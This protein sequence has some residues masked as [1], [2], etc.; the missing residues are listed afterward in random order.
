MPH[1][2]E[3]LIK[4]GGIEA[5]LKNMGEDITELKNKV[6]IQNGRVGKM[7]SWKTGMYMAG[8]VVVFVIVGVAV[9]LWYFAG[10]VIAQGEK[11]ASVS[12]KVNI[13]QTK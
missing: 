6:G 13:I 3:I 8:S 5:T 9:M 4:L 2:E 10:Q 12:A 7:E 1:Q 11:I